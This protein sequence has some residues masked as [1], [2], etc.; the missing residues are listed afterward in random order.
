MLK[1]TRVQKGMTFA[2]CSIQLFGSDSKN[3]ISL[4]LK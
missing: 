1:I 2:I 3:L 4:S